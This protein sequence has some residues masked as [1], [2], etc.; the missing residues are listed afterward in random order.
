METANVRKSRKIAQMIRRLIGD[1]RKETTISVDIAKDAF[2]MID[3]LAKE[4]L[5]MPLRNCD[6]GTAEEQEER[7]LKLKREYV[8][9]LATCPAEG[10]SF[11]P[12][13]I[14]WAQMPYDGGGAE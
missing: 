4:L 5:I 6:V 3:D 8:D 11:F 7:Y 1:I 2:D 13:S 10:Q 14:Y 12:D 9:R